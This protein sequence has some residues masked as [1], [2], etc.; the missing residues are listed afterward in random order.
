MPLC[1][2][3]SCSTSKH[4]LRSMTAVDLIDVARHVP[5][6]SSEWDPNEVQI[7][8]DEIVED[9]VARCNSTYFWPAHPQDEGAENGDS[10]LYLGAAGVIWALHHLARTGATRHRR[11]FE[12]DLDRLIEVARKQRVTLGAYGL[13]G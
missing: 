10:S 4:G 13:H 12:S 2:A 1:S 11:D 7:A 8:I 3:N 5:I 6:S 9:A